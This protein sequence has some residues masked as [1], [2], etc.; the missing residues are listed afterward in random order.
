[1]RRNVRRLNREVGHLPSSRVAQSGELGLPYAQSSSQSA[2]QSSYQTV[3]PNVSSNA[4]ADWG[5]TVF[6]TDSS[7]SP[8]PKSP[9]DQGNKS[10]S[11]TPGMSQM[12]L[13]VLQDGDDSIGASSMPPPQAMFDNSARKKTKPNSRKAAN[14]SGLSRLSFLVYYCY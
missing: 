2:Y 13:G 4:V 14:L 9:N 10:Q 1:M 12:L 3:T 7:M 5:A 6:G 8:M 11:S